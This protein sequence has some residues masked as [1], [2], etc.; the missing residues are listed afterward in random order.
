MCGSGGG[1]GG[2]GAGVGRGLHT[3][4]SSGTRVF[5]STH[6][7]GFHHKQKN[8]KTASLSA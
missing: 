4:P 8:R 3:V 2:G 7:L 5:V 6:M 1:A